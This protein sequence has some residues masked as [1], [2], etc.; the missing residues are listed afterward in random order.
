MAGRKKE[1]QV[2]QTIDTQ[3]EWEEYLTKEGLI[4]NISKQCHR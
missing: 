4:G 1:A 3:E 2:Q